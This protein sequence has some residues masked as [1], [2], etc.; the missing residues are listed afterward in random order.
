MK[1][2]LVFIGMTGSGKTSF[3]KKLSQKLGLS[4]IDTDEV[5]E[6]TTYQSIPELFEIGEAH[7]RMI[8]S[9]TCRRV[10][11]ETTHSIIS[12]GGGV[13]LKK[14]N[15]QALKKTGWIVFIDRPVDNIVEDIRVDHRPL[16]KDGTDKLYQ[17]YDERIELYRSAADFVVKND[18]SEAYVLKTIE[19]NLPETIKKGV[20]K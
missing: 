15:I 8:E 14:E 16:L 20:S 18:S 13:V 1:T 7:F 17:L 3:G 4:F 5:I 19:Q 2:N 11:S 9:D 10:A 6:K 12:C